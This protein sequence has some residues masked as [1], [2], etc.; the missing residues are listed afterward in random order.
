MAA[1]ARRSI[2]AVLDNIGMQHQVAILV[3]GVQSLP[4]RDHRIEIAQD[5]AGLDGPKA[6]SGHP[7]AAL[8]NTPMPQKRLD[9]LKTQPVKLV[10]RAQ[11]V[12]LLRVA[13]DAGGREHAVEHLAVI[14]L[15]NVLA[16]QTQCIHDVGHHHAHFG[17]GFGA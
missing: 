8:I 17:I 7:G 16:R 14:D 3:A 6:G 10:D 5:V 9:T 4:C 15:D 11:H 13:G 12:E 1:L 2:G